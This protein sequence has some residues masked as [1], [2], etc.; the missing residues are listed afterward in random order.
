MACRIHASIFL[1]VLVENFYHKLQAIVKWMSTQRILERYWPVTMTFEVTKVSVVIQ[2]QVTQWLYPPTHN[3]CH[4]S[5]PCSQFVMLP[6]RPLDHGVMKTCASIKEVALTIPTIFGGVNN[7]A[8]VMCEADLVHSIFLAVYCLQKPVYHMELP[9][10]K[11][12]E[13]FQTWRAL[14]GLK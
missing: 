3:T 8:R 13:W 9:T 10:I 6:P 12:G 4:T 1:A 5:I 7:W 14:F 2:G 11:A